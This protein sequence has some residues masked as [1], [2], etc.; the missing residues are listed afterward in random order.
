MALGKDQGLQDSGARP[1]EGLNRIK[2]TRSSEGLL[3]TQSVVG[4]QQDD[5]YE[6]GFRDVTCAYAAEAKV[7]SSAVGESRKGS[8]FAL[9]GCISADR[10]SL[11]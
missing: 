6:W 9:N 1:P 5:L 3:L 4:F 2:R 11:L 10:M 7:H 8:R